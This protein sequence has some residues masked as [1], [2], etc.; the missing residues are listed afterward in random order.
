[1]SFSFVCQSRPWL[2]NEIGG[3]FWYG[4]DAP[5][6]TAYV[7]FFSAQDSIPDSYITGKQSVFNRKSSWWPFNLVNQLLNLKYSYMIK[8]VTREY[9]EAEDVA[10]RMLL[11]T[12]QE[13][14]RAEDH[15]IRAI[16]EKNTNKHA[17]WV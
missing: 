12:E 14:L 16:L 15:K 8:D 9:L 10:R 7:P 13:A 17:D 6:G 11:E 3:V 4:Q 1:T 5:H 2:R